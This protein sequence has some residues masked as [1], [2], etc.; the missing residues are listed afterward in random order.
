MTK[1]SLQTCSSNISFVLL[2][3]AMISLVFFV[4]YPNEFRLQSMVTS[5]PS[6][7]TNFMETVSLKPDFRLLVGIL[8]LPDSYERRH[9]VRHAYALQSNVSDAR[10]DVR[11]VFCNLTKEEQR[12]L[13]AMEIMI[14]NDI[15]ILNCTENMDNG[16]TYTYFSS[17]PKILEGINGI[18][19]P[20]DYVMKTDDDTYFRLQNL[21]ESLR[22]LPREDMYYGFL[23]PCHD[24]GAP[25]SYMSGMGYVLSWDLV[26]WIATSEM[27]RDHQVGPE[28][29]VTGSWLRAGGRG[30]NRFDMKLAMYDYM[31]EPRLCSRHEFVPDTIAVHK[32]KNNLRWATTLKYFNAAEG[33]K[34]SKLYHL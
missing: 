15:I 26:E 29:L 8:T 5:R 4:I 33:L 18:E 3:A 31:E 16:K 34:P 2:S 19:R 21:A 17:L 12:V 30:K 7:L 28:D 11:F 32:L 22:R 14:Y 25:N 6:S 13:V 1:P 20:Y 23:T 24:R 27:P 10:I 9:L